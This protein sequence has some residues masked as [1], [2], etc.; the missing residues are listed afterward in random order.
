MIH[1]LPERL[2]LLATAEAGRTQQGC[3]PVAR[4]E[5]VVS[6]L[7]SN[8][9]D[10]QVALELGKDP[11]GIRYLAGPIEGEVMLKCQRCLEPVSRKL[12][13]KFRLGLVRDETLA[14]SLPERYEALIVTG[15]PSSIADIVSDEVLL[16][17]PLVPLH[18]ED[19]SDCRE[20]LKDY[21]PG[22]EARES[23]FAVLAGLKQKQP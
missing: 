4:L 23:P 5:R 6:A 9:G 17:L 12:D 8:E 22:D 10:L 11:A 7:A 3:I 18:A 16:A 2:D 1:H 13:L 20:F 14:S 21:Q 19:D 15:E